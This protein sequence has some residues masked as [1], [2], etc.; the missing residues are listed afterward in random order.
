MMAT[1]TRPGPRER[2]L[3]AARDLTYTEG[4]HVG[5]DA[6]LKKADVARA[7]LYQHFGGKDGLV[8]EVLRTM[9]GTKRY[10]DVMDAAGPTPR[11]RI[12]AIFDEMERV[13]TTP[14]YR[15]CRFT[16][17]ELSLDAPDHPIHAEVRTFKEALHQLFTEELERHGHPSPAFGADQ[18]VVL[19]DGIQVH[20]VTRPNA[21]PALAAKA[22]VEAVLTA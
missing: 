6:I 19:L 18:I 3:D 9:P 13:T 5:V 1:T 16:K 10:R 8:A 15:G 2:L 4:M 14:D 22:L 11:D 21:H 7:S 17:A 20:A 12:L